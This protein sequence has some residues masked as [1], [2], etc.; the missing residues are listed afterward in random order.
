VAAVYP[1]LVRYGLTGRPLTVR[2]DELPAMLLNEIQRQRR[3]L[4]AQGAQLE[5]QAA[6]LAAAAARLARRES[7]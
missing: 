2:Y 4:E 6:E 3:E 7:R 1:E 5:A